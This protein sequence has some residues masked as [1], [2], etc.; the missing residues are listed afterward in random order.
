[1]D[2]QRRETR[3]E[4]GARD[5]EEGE[6]MRNLRV[7]RDERTFTFEEKKE[8]EKKRK[9]KYIYIYIFSSGFGF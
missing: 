2:A 5:L 9:G 8:E 7:E 6:G 1:M 4:R 3:E